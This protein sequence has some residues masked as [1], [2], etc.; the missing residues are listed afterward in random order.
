[1]DIAHSQRPQIPKVVEQPLRKR[2]KAVSFEVPGGV[3]RQIRGCGEDGLMRNEGITSR[4]GSIPD[5]E[6]ALLI[7]S[8]IRTNVTSSHDTEATT[9]PVREKASNKPG[10]FQGSCESNR[11]T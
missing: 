11:T 7:P 1:M 6:P 3:P 2:S 10:S 9:N 8:S 5:R 4:S